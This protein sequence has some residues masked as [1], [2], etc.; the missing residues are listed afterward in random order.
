MRNQLG[1]DRAI[2]PRP[3]LFSMASRSKRSNGATEHV[4]GNP[5][6]IALVSRG[7]YGVSEHPGTTSGRVRQGGWEGTLARSDPARSPAVRDAPPDQ[8][9]ERRFEHSS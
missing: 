1:E 9:E 2:I 7:S 3:S 8:S 6:S 4:A 5:H